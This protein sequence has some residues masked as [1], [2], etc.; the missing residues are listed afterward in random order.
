MVITVPKGA[1]Q[2]VAKKAFVLRSEFLGAG[3]ALGV[4]DVE[5][6]IAGLAHYVF[7]YKEDDIEFEEGFILSGESLIPLF[8]E[9][10]EEEGVDLKTAKV[11]IA[12]ASKYKINPKFMDLGEKNEK[13]ARSFV[14]KFG[15]A[16]DNL[17]MK[18]GLT[19]I[20]LLEVDLKTKK[21][22]LKYTGKEVVL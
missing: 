22:L 1:F 4:L 17:I 20:T 5:N 16:E 14:K 10:L 21:V 13:V 6:E 8:L 3:I 12:G 11:V 19:V 2:I 15:I 18:T 7:P 9:K